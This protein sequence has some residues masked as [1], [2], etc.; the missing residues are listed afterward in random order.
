MENPYLKMLPKPAPEDEREAVMALRQ[1]AEALQQYPGKD[2]DVEVF[3]TTHPECGS[4]NPVEVK[5][6]VNVP[7]TDY[8]NIVLVAHCKGEKGFPTEVDPYF[9]GGAFPNGF[10]PCRSRVELDAVLQ[11]FV[12]SPEILSLLDYMNR[13]AQGIKK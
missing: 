9:A 4:D 3:I 1:F 5:M 7:K 2:K 13:H 12:K 6:V 11:R 10:E 8:V